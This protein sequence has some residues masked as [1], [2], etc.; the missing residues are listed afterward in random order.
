MKIGKVPDQGIDQPSNRLPY[1]TSRAI[2]K[3]GSLIHHVKRLDP[4]LSNIVSI[5]FLNIL[6]LNVI[7]GFTF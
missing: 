3:S 2:V 7:M 5:E 4:I 1:N 6:K